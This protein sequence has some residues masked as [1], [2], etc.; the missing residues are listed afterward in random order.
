MK[1]FPKFLASWKFIQKVPQTLIKKQDTKKKSWQ[2]HS[3]TYR[4][5]ILYIL[6]YNYNR[7]ITMEN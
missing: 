3:H 6:I 2:K 5:N 7:Q 1:N 4:E